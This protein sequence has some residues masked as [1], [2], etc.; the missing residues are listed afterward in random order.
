M[1]GKGS[2][3]WGNYQRREAT[4][5]CL[6]LDTG[7]ILPLIKEFRSGSL[8][9]KNRKTEEALQVN[10]IISIRKFIKK[11]CFSISFVRF[12]K[13][14][15]VEI[16]HLE[17]TMIGPKRK[18]YWFLCPGSLAEEPCGHRVK[19]LFLRP[20]SNKFLC[21]F[22][23]DLTYVSSQQSYYR[24]RFNKLFNSFCH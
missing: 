8:I 6:I 2:S 15:F 18:R 19:K 14:E 17:T 23:A 13:N 22:C 7:F 1:G 3:R 21:R 16:L 24:N 20:D 4:E 9:L 12:P 10:F 11:S 5:N